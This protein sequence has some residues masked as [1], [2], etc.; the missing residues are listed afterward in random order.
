MK[1]KSIVAVSYLV[2]LHLFLIAVLFESN[3]LDNLKRK[4]DDHPREKSAYFDLMTNYHQW[5]D[6]LLPEGI[7]LFIGDSITQGLATQAIIA[8]SIN[9]GIGRDT[10]QGVLLRLPY[11]QSIHRAKGI[12]LAVGVNDL[13]HR[14][15]TEIVENYQK[16]LDYFPQDKKIFVSSILPLDGRARE[17]AITKNPRIMAIN[18]SLK[19]LTKNYKNAVFINAHPILKDTDGNL[20]R[21]YHVGDGVHLSEMGYVAWINILKE[22]LNTV[23]DL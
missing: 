21:D 19:M 1:T 8:P 11:Y 14:S 15:N 18:R 12:V 16:I 2:F 9:Y 23:E 4:L 3:M 10:T 5:I 7:T 6:P 13:R 20:K 17:S 22:N